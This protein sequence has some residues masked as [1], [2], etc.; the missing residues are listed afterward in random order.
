MSIRPSDNQPFDCTTFVWKALN[1][2]GSELHLFWAKSFPY[3]NCLCRTTDIA[4]VGT[5]LYIF[6]MMK[7]RAKIQTEVLGH[8][9]RL[10]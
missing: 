8:S 5:I 3:S 2:H 9:R 10:D 1:V 6:I 7:C 4:A